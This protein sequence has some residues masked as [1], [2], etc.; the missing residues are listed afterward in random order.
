MVAS[1]PQNETLQ[2]A[3]SHIFLEVTQFDEISTVLENEGAKDRKSLFK[4]LC[5]CGG[6]SI[7]N[8]Q[9][10]YQLSVLAQGEL[11]SMALMSV[12]LPPRICQRM[13][14]ENSHASP[15]FGLLLN[16]HS[17]ILND[18]VTEVRT[19]NHR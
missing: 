8:V 5:A 16:H 1:V 9:S 15:H 19:T 13:P 3:I 17:L 6:N 14:I 7:M 12:P 18:L 4:V 2:A 10:V 11:E